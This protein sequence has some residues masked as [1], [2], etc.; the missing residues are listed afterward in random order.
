MLLHFPLAH[1]ASTIHP[2]ANCDKSAWF[3]VA[4]KAG[5]GFRLFTYHI[6]KERFVFLLCLGG[7]IILN[8]LKVVLS[9]CN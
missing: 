6:S 5:N 7:E 9:I 4:N 1:S 3:T 2:P 8:I